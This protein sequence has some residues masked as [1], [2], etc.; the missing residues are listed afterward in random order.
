[1]AEEKGMLKTCD[2]CGKT[3]FLKCTG[4][5][6]MDGGFTRW[7]EFEPA[8]Q[9]WDYV[10]DVGTLCPDCM[11]DYNFMIDNFKRGCAKKVDDD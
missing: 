2:R 3:I 5:G 9:G 8:P 7:N 11:C 1:M 6:E 10:R 4:E